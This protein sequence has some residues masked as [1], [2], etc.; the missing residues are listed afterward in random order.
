MEDEGVAM[1]HFYDGFEKQ[2]IAIFKKWPDAIRGWIRKQHAPKAKIRNIAGMG[3]V[4][5]GAAAY[6]VHKAVDS[7]IGPGHE[8]RGDW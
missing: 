4:G 3:I 1:N 2:S 6:G 8:L 7:A 5:T